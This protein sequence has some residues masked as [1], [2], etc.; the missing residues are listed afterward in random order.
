MN[1]RSIYSFFVFQK[2]LTFSHKI[3]ISCYW[4][5]EKNPRFSGFSYVEINLK[6]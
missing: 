4:I 2:G 6:N 3:D 1:N 5:F